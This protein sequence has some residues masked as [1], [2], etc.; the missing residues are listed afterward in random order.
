MLI[1]I[2]CIGCGEQSPSQDDPTLLCPV[3]CHNP[4]YATYLAY[5]VKKVS[6]SEI[7]NEIG[8]WM[9][10]QGQGLINDGQ[11][12]EGHVLKDRARYVLEDDLT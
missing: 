10:K 4:K 2:R 7:L 3:C 8:E 5:Y 1:T 12:E 11:I 6:R 9:V